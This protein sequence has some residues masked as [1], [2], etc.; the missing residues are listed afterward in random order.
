MANLFQVNGTDVTGITFNN[1]TAFPQATENLIGMIELATQTEA[2]NLTSP[3]N[4]HV[5]S[6][7]RL[8]QAIT[9]R[10]A[11]A[12]E[13]LDATEATKLMT[14]QR[15]EEFFNNK[16]IVSASAPTAADWEDGQIWF[17]YA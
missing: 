17:E 2:E 6:L 9:A 12:T 16:I 8:Q 3:S 11:N 7:L 5:A 14:P 13:A 15:A 4:R 1:L 10:L